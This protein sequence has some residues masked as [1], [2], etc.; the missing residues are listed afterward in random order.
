MT[1]KILHWTRNFSSPSETFI[2]NLIYKLQEIDKYENYVFAHR[3]LLKKERKIKNYIGTP[4]IIRVIDLIIKKSLSLLKIACFISSFEELYIKS[5]VFKRKYDLIH[6]HFGWAA[7]SYY[8]YVTEKRKNWPVLISMHGTDVMKNNNHEN[9]EGVLKD[10]SHNYYSHFTVPSQFLKNELIK[11]GIS[12]NKITVLYN[13]INEELFLSHRKQNSND[14][15]INKPIKIINNSRLVAWKGHKYLIEGFSL[16]RKYYNNATLT[17]IG[18]GKLRQE[19]EHL[20]K[21]LNIEDNVRF[22]GFQPYMNIPE[23]LQQHDIYVQP[24]IHD[25][26]TGQVESFGISVLEAITVGLPVIVTNTGG[27]PE[28]VGAENKYCKIINPERSIEICNSLLSFM[29]NK[30]INENNWSYARE[31]LDI[32]SN[33]KYFKSVETLYD[34]IMSSGKTPT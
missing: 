20:T 29:E 17:I 10:L 14:I 3:R 13:T 16:F 18:D 34:T 31:R 24:S 8:K 25:K 23:I 2:Y 5:I 15:K 21:N 33:I 12:E 30:C 27:L 32:F 6:C 19:L 4:I 7:Y 28:V 22:M 26:K 9:Y 11:K 1:K